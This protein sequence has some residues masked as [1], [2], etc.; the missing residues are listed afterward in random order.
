VSN[1]KALK[2]AV[3]TPDNA[4]GDKVQALTFNALP[5]T[6]EINFN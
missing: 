5:N 3:I 2:G 6:S 1:G 4:T